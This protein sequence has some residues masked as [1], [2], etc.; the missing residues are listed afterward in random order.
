LLPFDGDPSFLVRTALPLAEV[1]KALSETKATEVLAFVDA[2]FS[3]SGGRSVLPPGARPLVHVRESTPANKIAIFSA[4]EGAEIS[5]PTP[6]GKSGLFSATLLDAVRTG[7]A[8]SD[9]DGRITLQE[10]SDWVRPRVARIAR[11][12]NR[13]QHPAVVIG[14]G[15]GAPTAFAVEWGLPTR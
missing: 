2:C 9:G 14:S 13:E 3:G 10:L 11:E 5:G 1:A 8:D 4:S 7:A 15:M 6:D 12:A